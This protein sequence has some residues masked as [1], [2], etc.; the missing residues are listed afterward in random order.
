[1]YRQ[2]LDTYRNAYQATFHGNRAP[3]IFG[4]HFNTY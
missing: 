3:L 1:M 2:V 4:S